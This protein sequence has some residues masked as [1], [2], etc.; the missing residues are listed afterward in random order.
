[1]SIGTMILIFC[2]INQHGSSDPACHHYVVEC[3]EHRK[4]LVTEA[5]AY[6]R[7]STQWTLNKGKQLGRC[8]N[9][10]IEINKERFK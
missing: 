1:M 2:A 4:V 7:C 5:N 10:D 8:L 6:S 3:I 9:P